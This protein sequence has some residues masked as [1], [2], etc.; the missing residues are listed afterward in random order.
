MKYREK[1]L[2]W[3]TMVKAIVNRKLQMHLGHILEVLNEYTNVN[4]KDEYITICKEP[5]IIFF[6]NVES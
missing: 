2:H 4:P 1:D 5:D 3:F 6:I